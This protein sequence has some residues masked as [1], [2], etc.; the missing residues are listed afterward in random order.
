MIVDCADQVSIF[1][2]Q[3]DPLRPLLTEMSE[4]LFQGKEEIK[5]PKLLYCDDKSSLSG[6]FLVCPFYVFDRHMLNVMAV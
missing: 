2:A 4:L 6:V 5:A 1:P 3:A